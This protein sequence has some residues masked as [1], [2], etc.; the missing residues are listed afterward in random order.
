M[1]ELIPQ[2]VTKR[3]AFM[4]YLTDGVTP[5]TGKTIAVT[6]SKNGAAFGNPSAGATNATEIASGWYFFDSSTTDTGTLGPLLVHGTGTGVDPV[7]LQYTVGAIALTAAERNAIADAFLDRADAIETGL[8]PRGVLRLIGAACAGLASGL[9]TVTAVY[10]NAV[11]NSK[12][13][14]T[15]TVDPDGNRTAITWDVT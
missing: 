5:A 13:R 3:I 7:D 12:P 9:A 15:A 2:S 4:A 8:T 6:I 14:I 10:R 11:Q 1:S